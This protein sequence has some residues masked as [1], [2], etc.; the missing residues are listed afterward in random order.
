MLGYKVSHQC[1]SGLLIG[2]KIPDPNRSS[3]IG[4]AGPIKGEQPTF[5]SLEFMLLLTG[6]GWCGYTEAIIPPQ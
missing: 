5:V 1:I 4:M 2:K 6:M 3:L